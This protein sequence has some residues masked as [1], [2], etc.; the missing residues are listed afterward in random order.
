[1]SGVTF[2]DS[3]IMI[4]A[5][6]NI[7]MGETIRYCNEDV[8]KLRLQQQENQHMKLLAKT[9]IRVTR[10]LSRKNRIGTSV[11]EPKILLRD[12]QKVKELVKKCGKVIIKKNLTLSDATNRH[13]MR[14]KLGGKRKYKHFQKK[15]YIEIIKMMLE[16]KLP[17]EDYFHF[18]ELQRQLQ[19][20]Y[21]YRHHHKHHHRHH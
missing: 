18:G 5:A 20:E 11:R 14:R 1:M 3:E 6:S 13:S 2:S 7:C 9:N 4:D 12:V 17:H 19:S 16:K 21:Q 8:H 10:Y 15:G